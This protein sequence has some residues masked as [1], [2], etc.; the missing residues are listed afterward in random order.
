MAT[1]IFDT[2]MAKDL[3]AQGKIVAIP[4]E[5]VYGL[6]GSPKNIEVVL[7]IYD[8]KKRP[9]DK[10]LAINIHPSWDI[11]QW[12]INIPDYVFKL[13]Q[14]FWPGPL[15]IIV[16]ANPKQV[17][18]FLIGPQNTI[19][20]RCPNHPMTLDVL[21]QLGDVLV[22]P[23]AN[24][25]HQLSPTNALQVMDYFQD[26]DIAIL[27]GGACELGIESTIL[28]ANDANNY[29][30]LRVGAVSID[31]ISQ[32][33]GFPARKI[34]SPKHQGLLNIPIYYF[35][36]TSEVLKY[37]EKH[38]KTQYLCIAR[39]KHLKNIPTSQQ[40]L[41]PDSIKA[42]EKS[43]Y[44]ILQKSQKDHRQIIFIE[45]FEKYPSL[46]EIIQ[47]HAKPIAYA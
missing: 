21:Q 13:T 42:I 39:T 9:M 29:E 15:S 30:I 3:L 4:T 22:A 7:A 5:T 2:Q 44:D 18:S 34:L 17:P 40:Y 19:A 41:L 12:G 38:P 32:C 28:K 16:E 25:S 27:D 10:A 31:A 33:I 24:P 11:R 26:T 45:S 14:T 8:L 47:K 35:K 36:E 20:L 6:A 46:H 23:S 37:L 1:I 43:F